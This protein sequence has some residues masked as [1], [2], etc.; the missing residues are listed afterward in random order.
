MSWSGNCS[1][2]HKGS[3]TKWRLEQREGLREREQVCRHWF[4][5]FLQ[6]WN[7]SFCIPIMADWIFDIRTFSHTNHTVY[8]HF[9]ICIVSLQLAHGWVVLPESP[10]DIRPPSGGSH[11][12]VLP[13]ASTKR[14][15]KGKH[16]SGQHFHG[17]SLAWLVWLA[18]WPVNLYLFISFLFVLFFSFF[19]SMCVWIMAMLFWIPY[20]SSPKAHNIL[21]YLGNPRIV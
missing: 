6:R 20:K 11:R 4:Y 10:L 16:L 15:S 3:D 18:D 21:I 9:L 12:W 17:W 14:R 7:K 1:G 13:T 2:T 8:G 19:L 5:Q